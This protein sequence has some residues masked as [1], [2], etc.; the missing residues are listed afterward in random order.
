MT[1]FCI[2]FYESYLSTTGE[3]CPK[4][5]YPIVMSPYLST[6]S[7]QLLGGGRRG[8]DTNPGLFSLKSTSHSFSPFYQSSC[9][10]GQ[11]FINLLSCPS[12]FRPLLVLLSCVFTFFLSFLAGKS[13]FVTP[14]LIFERG[15]YSN[16]ES[17]RSKQVRY[18]LSHLLP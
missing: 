15:L 16:P 18:Q 7:F 14:L 12:S 3:I 9:P 2:A 4:V 17:F 6:L 10:P 11:P 13:V 8:A 5:F 1:T